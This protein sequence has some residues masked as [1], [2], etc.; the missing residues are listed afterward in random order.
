MVEFLKS[1]YHI[2]L[3]FTI[4]VV[5]IVN[6]RQYFDTAL[7]Y[8]PIYIAYTFF[9]ELLGYFIIT[10]EHF[11]FF[12]DLAYS[13]HNVAIYNLYNVLVFSFFS[14]VY[15]QVLKKNSHKTKVRRGSLIIL[16][17]YF[18]SSI[19]QDPRHTGLFYSEALASFFMVYIILLYLKEKKITNKALLNKKNLM[20]WVSL[21]LLLFHIVYPFLYI[22]GFLK[23]EIWIEYHFRDILKILIVISYSFFLVGLILG[24][25]RAFN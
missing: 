20:L 25:R 23:P 14:W 24:R 1:Q 9:T 11:S 16:S 18:I 21:G 7:K 5:A 3:Y 17:T 12:S 4:L 6:Y 13:W 2:I 22:T 15:H 8:F 19:F 10:Y